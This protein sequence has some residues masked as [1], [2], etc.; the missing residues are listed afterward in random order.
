MKRLE[1]RSE[2][3]HSTEH[4]GLAVVWRRVLV[5]LVAW[6]VAF[7]TLVAGCP[8]STANGAESQVLD[9][10]TKAN[11]AQESDSQTDTKDDSQSQPIRAE[12]VAAERQSVRAVRC[13]E[14]QPVRPVGC[15]EQRSTRGTAD[16]RH[17]LYGH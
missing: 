16:P 5:A 9:S 10:L 8:A 12:P 14:Q 2:S 7:A 11:V 6:L 4:G 17:L 3:L 15:T 13:A 1:H